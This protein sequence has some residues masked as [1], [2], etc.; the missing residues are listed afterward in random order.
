MVG[1]WGSRSEGY[2]GGEDSDETHCCGM[3]VFVFGDRVLSSGGRCKGV[4]KG[5]GARR[6]TSIRFMLG[7]STLNVAGRVKQAVLVRSK[8]LP[9]YSSGMRQM[10]LASQHPP[11]ASRSPFPQSQTSVLFDSHLHHSV[12]L[13]RMKPEEYST[14]PHTSLSYGHLGTKHEVRMVDCRV[15][16]SCFLL[17]MIPTPGRLLRCTDGRNRKCLPTDGR[18]CDGQNGENGKEAHCGW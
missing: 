1:C 7:D 15:A 3:E 6:S 12:S 2:K 18:A 13:H 16:H 11:L 8:A 9:E 5:S 10:H 17:S 4:G 14:G